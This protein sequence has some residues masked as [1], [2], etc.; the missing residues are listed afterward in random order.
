MSDI[1]TVEKDKSYKECH[2]ETT[3]M[4]VWAVKTY[5]VVG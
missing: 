4:V 2:K 3:L 1:L 5:D